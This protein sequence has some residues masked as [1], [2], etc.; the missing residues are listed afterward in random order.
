MKKVVK[1]RKVKEK[2]A[3]KIGE[4]KVRVSQKF[5][6]ALAIVSM[7]GFAGIISQTI[8]NYDLSYYV[9]SFLMLIIG[10]ALIVESKIKKLKSLERGLT[11]SNI[12]HLTTVV[13]GSIAILAGIFSFPPI[14]ITTPGF[15]AIKGIIAI[16]AVI[17]IGIQTWVI[18]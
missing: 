14:R 10:L 12:T 18:G 5:V 16:I 11:S 4:G 8:F 13:I 7:L 2:P 6:T 17:V 3:G 15:L 1:K 9:E